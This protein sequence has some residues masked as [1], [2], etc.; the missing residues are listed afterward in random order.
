MATHQKSSDDN[1]NLSYLSYLYSILKRAQENDCAVTT[2][3][4]TI[5]KFRLRY[6]NTISQIRIEPGAELDI[7]SIK[8]PKN[9]PR[10]L[11]SQL[12]AQEL[13]DLDSIPVPISAALLVS[14]EFLT[15]DFAGTDTPPFLTLFQYYHP[16]HYRTYYLFAYHNRSMESRTYTVQELLQLRDTISH[17][18]L[19][20]LKANHEVGKYSL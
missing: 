1:P 18:T 7:S 5:A 15:K 10:F 16:K 4:L 9:T 11:L 14:C 13:A 2:Y 12:E 19:N 20:K 3:Q 17:A 6:S 8:P